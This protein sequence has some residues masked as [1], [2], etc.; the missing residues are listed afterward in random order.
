MKD[1][2]KLIL[3]GGSG[4]CRDVIELIKSIN[5]KLFRYKILGILDDSIPLGK[6]NN[7]VKVLGPIS[8]YSIRNIFK[9]SIHGS[10]AVS[11]KIY[12]QP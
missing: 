6:L 5:K 12:L 7:G 2:I 4:T 3:V 9:G 11:K 10:V 1:I 8:D